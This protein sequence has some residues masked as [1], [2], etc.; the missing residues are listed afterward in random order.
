MRAFVFM[1]PPIVLAAAGSLMGRS[2]S[3]PSEPR[4]AN[5]SD[6][7]F[8]GLDA[9][10]SL[11]GKAQLMPLERR[12]P[13]ERICYAPPLE[14]PPGEQAYRSDISSVSREGARASAAAT[15]EPSDVLSVR[16]HRSAG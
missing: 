13:L 4:L 6:S 8:L 15:S 10:V 2:Q 11:Q 7:V 1:V 12:A 9:A 5:S 16:P 14:F 3:T